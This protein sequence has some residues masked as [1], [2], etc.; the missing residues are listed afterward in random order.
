MGE[1]ILDVSVLPQMA[2]KTLASGQWSVT[3]ESK[4]LAFPGRKDSR[5]TVQ[6]SV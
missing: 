4:A 1:S 2:L 6:S 5:D 3:G